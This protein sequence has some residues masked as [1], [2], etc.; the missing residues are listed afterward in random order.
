MKRTVWVFLTALLAFGTWTAVRPATVHACSCAGA[1]SLEAQ[2][3]RDT[4][5]FTGKVVRLT[6]PAK[7]IFQS[8][9]DP[10]RVQFEVKTVWKGTLSAQATVY[11]ALSSASCGYDDFQVNEDYLVFAHG[12]SNRLETG[13]CDGNKTLAAAQSELQALGAGY[14][15]VRMK[16]PLPRRSGAAAIALV[17][18]GVLIAALLLTK[19]IWRRRG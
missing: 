9:A 12:Q 2:L 1:T 4:A 15:P 10:V 13:L 16:E 18:A 7:G 8:S 14:E 5:V 11:T 6:A 19:L 3:N 17:S